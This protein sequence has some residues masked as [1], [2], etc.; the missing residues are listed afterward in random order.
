M[1][2][3][4]LGVLELGL[5]STTLSGCV[6]RLLAA[7]GRLCAA[8]FGLASLSG[9]FYAFEYPSALFSLA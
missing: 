6:L 5:L 4:L 7:R 9:A 3:Q 8:A 1:D 2:R